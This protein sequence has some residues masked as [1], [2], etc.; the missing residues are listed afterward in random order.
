MIANLTRDGVL[1]HFLSLNENADAMNND[2]K[3]LTL[4]K[5]KQ[6]AEVFECGLASDKAGTIEKIM[7]AI[8]RSFKEDEPDKEPDASEPDEEEGEEPD[9]EEGEEPDEEEGE[10]PDEEEG[11]EPDEE[12]GEE[13]DEDPDAS[14]S[15]DDDIPD[16]S[17]K[18]V[19][20]IVELQVNPK[21]RRFIPRPSK[22]DYDRTKR[23]I[24]QAIAAGEGLSER[25]KVRTGPALTDP[26]EII[27]GHTRYEILKELNIPI[28]EDMI[29]I[30]AINDDQVEMEMFRLNVTRRHMTDA[31]KIKLANKFLPQIKADRQIMRKAAKEAERAAKEAAKK[32][33][34]ATLRAKIKAENEERKRRIAEEKA[35]RKEAREAEKAAKE[36]ASKLKETRDAVAEVAGVAPGQV[37]LYDWCKKY[38]PQYLEEQINAGVEIGTIYGVAHD[39]WWNTVQRYSPEVLQE[40]RTGK[41]DLQT[42]YEEALENKPAEEHIAGP[43]ESLVIAIKE[44]YFK[45]LTKKY[46]APLEGKIDE[47]EANFINGLDAR[48]TKYAKTN[49]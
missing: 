15:N 3:G 45:T 40:I 16:V 14:E 12:E 8:G 2:L 36:A 5:L 48:I 42:A 1:E 26:Y 47:Y 25:I 7:K 43:F 11:E 49:A 33:A 18:R 28:T 39:K 27:D 4:G 32:A 46:G 20:P 17:P 37:K 6:V 30:L 22:E 23:S 44:A 34:K 19:Y 41:K 29:E 9:E 13:P 31:A 38:V 24:Q 35:A 10:E 21:F